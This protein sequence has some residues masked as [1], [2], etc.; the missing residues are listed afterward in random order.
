MPTQEKDTEN[1]RRPP[2]VQ[3]S[4]SNLQPSTPSFQP[5]TVAAALELYL[6]EIGKSRAGSTLNTYY[7]T[8]EKFKTTLAGRGC[9]PDKTPLAEMT[10][11][12]I[13]WFLDDLRILEPTTERSYL[14]A[15]IGFYEYVVAKNWLDLNLTEMRYFVR[16]RQRKLPQK[17]QRFPREQIDKLLHEMD[18][19]CD[20][21]FENDRERLAALRDRGLFYL[22]AD[23]GLRVSEACSLTVGQ[24]DFNEYELFAVGKGSKEARIRI[25]PRALERLQKYLNIRENFHDMPPSPADT[26]LF[27]RHDRRAG[28]K[29]RPISP[30]AVQQAVDRWVAQFLGPRYRTEITPHSFRHYFVTTVLRATGGD[31]E[32]ARKLARHAD[33][34][35][36]M[37]YAHLSDEELDRKYYEIFG[38]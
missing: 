29:L 28:K 1:H 3:P 37:R 8:I 25:S 36:T 4:T 18:T 12:W 17:A 22:L 19:L 13:Q 16:R 15:V 27:A 35:T 23:T 26:P 30:R 31:V 38:D 14:A 7:Y 32:V 33:I 24:V 6:E 2:T 34:S 9:P 5:S 20:R 21:P 11:E 10:N